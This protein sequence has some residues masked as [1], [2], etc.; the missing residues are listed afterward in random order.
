MA[1][2]KSLRPY[3]A[4]DVRVTSL[5]EHGRAQ[6]NWAR[7]VTKKTSQWIWLNFKVYKTKCSKI[8]FRAKIHNAFHG[9]Q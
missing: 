7:V 1:D 9:V 3:T 5:N 8:L 2:I 6:S 4:Y